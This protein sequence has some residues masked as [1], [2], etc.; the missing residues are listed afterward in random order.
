MGMA[1]TALW[2][3]AKL[4]VAQW[5][6]AASS[7]ERVE[8]VQS[9][10][11]LSHVGTAEGTE[12]GKKH[13]FA[14]I[15]CYEEFKER[16]PLRV[17]GDYEAD[18]ERMRQG[19]E[20]VLWPGLIPYYGQSSG[21]SNTAKMHKFLPISREQI[22]WQV[23]AGFDVCARYLDMSGDR[24]LTGGYQLGLLPP[25][26]V[27]QEG[28][29]GVASNPGIMQLHLPLAARPITL[30][31]GRIRE[32]EDYD[33][34]MRAIA[35]AYLDYDV[36]A[37]MG[38]TCWF[39]IMFDK[40]LEVAKER[41][42]KADTVSDLWP[43]LRVLFGGGIYAEPYR[44]V[45]D[46]R[47]GRKIVLMDNYNATEGGIF[48]ATDR[49]DDDGLL[50]IPDR[51]V[52]FEFVPRSEEGKPNATRVPLWRVETDVDYSV[53]VTTPSGLFSY[54]IGDYVRF[55]SLFP[56][57]IVFAGRTS[58][59]L[60]LT[61]ELTTYLEI[62]RAVAGAQKDQPA[63]IVD[64]CAS[65]EVG[66]EDSGKGR[67]VLFV[68]FDSDPPDPSK[69]LEA[70]DRELR[71]QNRVYREHRAK[72]VG[73]LPPVLVPLKKGAS[74]SFMDAIERTSVQNKFPRIVDERRREILLTFAQNGVVSYAD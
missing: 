56:H 31:K 7:R 53:V 32:I 35:E 37:L 27:K 55:K 49:M 33:K 43:N 17:Y 11:L 23:K 58:G 29:V 20:N 71:N 5:N 44:P 39:T 12:F 21:T 2:A 62:E 22:K 15:R 65:S 50:I 60:S 19:A 3:A 1:G 28:P 36:R 25:A 24:S 69:F 47:I 68:E 46:R 38:T 74:R 41:G 26:K 42:R 4:R 10:I 52:F 72:D 6:W 70:F 63:T 8:K 16:V 9:E 18:L 61:Q 40:L 14:G 59:M 51:G 57:R 66:V 64:F 45:I 30:P 13:D 54:M 67:Y 34:K 73:I 48:A